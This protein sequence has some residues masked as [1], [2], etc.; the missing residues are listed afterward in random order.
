MGRNGSQPKN[1]VVPENKTLPE[2]KL[3]MIKMYRNPQLASTIQMVIG[4]YHP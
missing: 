4:V 3:R 2:F 1:L